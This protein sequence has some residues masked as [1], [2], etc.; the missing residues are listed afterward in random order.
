MPAL[1]IGLGL[2]S[3]EFG[4]IGVLGRLG[5]L[6]SLGGGGGGL[7]S[8]VDDGEHGRVA[9]FGHLVLDLIG[10]RLDGHAGAVK[11]EGEEDLVALEAVVG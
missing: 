2:F 8:L 4:G 10:G 1:A 9:E 7:G 3:R 5:S 11:G 6:G